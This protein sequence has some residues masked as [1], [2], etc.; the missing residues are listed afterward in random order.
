[1]LTG[2]FFFFFLSSTISC[3]LSLRQ[4]K[5]LSE[6]RSPIARWLSPSVNTFSQWQAVPWKRLPIAQNTPTPHIP[7][8]HPRDPTRVESAKRYFCEAFLHC[9]LGGTF[10]ATFMELFMSGQRCRLLDIEG[11]FFFGYYTRALFSY[12]FYVDETVVMLGKMLD[13]ENV[14]EG[15]NNLCLGMSEDKRR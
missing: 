1:M 11:F 14:L 4:T 12:V 8:I 6:C 2:L 13:W 3:S 7:K 9:R 10:T 15:E 5:Y